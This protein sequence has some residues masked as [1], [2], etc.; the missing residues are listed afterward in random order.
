MPSS[1]VPS[2]TPSM[3]MF[4]DVFL[5]AEAGDENGGGPQRTSSLLY[6]PRRRIDKRGQRL[7]QVTPD[8][9]SV[10]VGVCICVCV[11]V[12]ICL[13]APLHRHSWNGWCTCVSRMKAC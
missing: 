8:I 6:S 5:G 11:R 10:C 9:R 3:V 7:P 4:D 13:I 1:S 12:R 2:A